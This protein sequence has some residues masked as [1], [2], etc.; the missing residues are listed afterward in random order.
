MDH[1]GA[2]P[3]AAVQHLDRA[4]HLAHGLAGQVN[5]GAHLGHKLLE[6]LPVQ[7]LHNHIDLLAVIPNVDDA[8]QVGAS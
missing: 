8:R 7:P 2:L 4:S 1:R 5:A 3:Q 6:R